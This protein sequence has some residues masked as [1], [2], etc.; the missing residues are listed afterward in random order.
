VELYLAHDRELARRA[1]Y[2]Q[3]EAD[4][5][6]AMREIGALTGYPPCCVDAFAQQDDRAN[7]S[8]NRYYSQARTRAPDGSTPVPWPW[9][10]NNLYTMV[11]P[12][13][14]CSYRC[15]QALAWA[16]ASLQEMGKVYPALLDELRGWLARPVLYFDHDHQL[17]FNGQYV[18]GRISYQGVAL[19]GS[20]SPH[21]AALAAAIGRGNLLRLDDR[22]LLIERNGQ[23]VLSLK[24]TD[25]ALGFVAPFGVGE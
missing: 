7:N 9:E 22:E 23:A 15:A 6:Q 8:R 4:P 18:D 14:P 20:G 24:R 21:L 1:A 25:P 19:P 11:V 13:Y 10:L 3:A 17:V 2:L 5:T 16:R 12:F